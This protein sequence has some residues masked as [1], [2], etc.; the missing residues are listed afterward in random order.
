MREVTSRLEAGQSSAPVAWWQ[1]CFACENAAVCLIVVL[2]ARTPAATQSFGE[3]CLYSDMDWRRKRARVDHVGADSSLAGRRCDDRAASRASP[4]ARPQHSESLLGRF[5]DRRNGPVTAVHPPPNNDESVQASLDQAFDVVQATFGDLD[6]AGDACDVP[7]ILRHAV[8]AV[9]A[10][11]HVNAVRQSDG[12]FESHVFVNDFWIVSSTGAPCEQDAVTQAYRE[13][14]RMLK[15]AKR[16]PAN[17][18]RQQQRSDPTKLR[19]LK[20]EPPDV[21]PDA[22]EPA[23]APL[24]LKMR[25]KNTLRKRAAAYTIPDFDAQ[26]DPSQVMLFHRLSAEVVRCGTVC[27]GRRVRELLEREVNAL[28]MSLALA[29]TVGVHQREPADYCHVFVENV[30]LASAKASNAAEAQEQ[31]CRAAWAKLRAKPLFVGPSLEFLGN[32][33]L[34]VASRGPQQKPFWG[35]LSPADCQ[36]AA[37]KIYL[38]YRLMSIILFCALSQMLRGQRIQDG[39]MALMKLK[40]AAGKL[41]LALSFSAGA[42]KRTVNVFIEGM[43]LTEG[44]GVTMEAAEVTAALAAV[45]MLRNGTVVPGP[46]VAGQKLLLYVPDDK[47]IDGRVLAKGVPCNNVV[48][49]VPDTFP[50]EFVEQHLSVYPAQLG[51]HNTELTRGTL[52]ALCLFAKLFAFRDLMRQAEGKE[53]LAAFVAQSAARAKLDVSCSPEQS[54]Q[55]QIAYVV[56]LNGLQ[57]A[58]GLGTDKV[59]ARLAAFSEVKRRIVGDVFTVSR[60]PCG[61]KL[62][63]LC[64]RSGFDTTSRGRPRLQFQASGSGQAGDAAQPAV[65]SP[66]HCEEMG[67]ALAR[68]AIMVTNDCRRGVSLATKMHSAATVCGLELLAQV[69]R[70]GQTEDWKGTLSLSGALLA[71]AVGPSKQSARSL[72]YESALRLIERPF[73]FTQIN[74]ESVVVSTTEREEHVEHNY[75]IP[76][77]AATSEAENPALGVAHGEAKQ[78][79]LVPET[80][81][82]NQQSSDEVSRAADSL[83]SAASF[84]TEGKVGV[85]GVN[86]AAEE[87][88]E[89]EA[90]EGGSGGDRVSSA[91]PI[92]D[93]K[94]KQAQLLKFVDI[95]NAVPEQGIPPGMLS[96]WLENIALRKGCTFSYKIQLCS[97]S[98]KPKV[99]DL[100]VDDIWV[101]C[102]E[103]MDD[104]QAKNDAVYAALRRLKRGPLRI[105]VSVVVKGKLQVFC[106]SDE[107]D[108]KDL[109]RIQR[110]QMRNDLGSLVLIEDRSGGP[111]GP[112]AILTMSASAN[113]V[114]YHFRPS[115]DG[116]YCT[117]ELAGH[118]LGS[119]VGQAK[120]SKHEAAAE[121]LQVLKSFVPTVVIK[122]RID[123]WGDEVAL[124]PEEPHTASGGPCGAQIPS[125]NVGHKLLTRMGWTGGAI[126]RA[127]TGIVQPVMPT[128]A[129]GRQGLGYGAQKKKGTKSPDQAL[130]RIA[131]KACLEYAKNVVLQDLVFSPALSKRLGTSLFETAKR[132]GLKCSRVKR[133][134]GKCYVV[135]HRM[136]PQQLL[137]KILSEGPTCK[138]EFVMPV[139]PSSPE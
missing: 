54:P 14:W 52:Q 106:S 18:T 27:D 29:N 77:R 87:V 95:A 63:L 2:Y 25:K 86:L 93:V 121:A 118:V 80:R 56:L 13:V 4:V 102:G 7:S 122:Q 17:S 89:S 11:I 23:S 129:S 92:F 47:H 49:L 15:A 75:V 46:N 36:A 84:L 33:E 5:G 108:M 115:D 66:L 32:D 30:W 126:G 134:H 38:P 58:R 41:D 114:P 71:C 60:T 50:R 16:A 107:G 39:Q 44:T 131:D 65:G 3:L 6:E 125:D 120:M 55:G 124:P 37:A 53:D 59:A 91:G 117:V 100:F 103:G 90:F 31:A 104:T 132:Y 74:G 70:V 127:G 139:Q 28:E 76:A 94:P 130:R 1:R 64:L 20:S 85:A 101:S 116:R 83:N 22:P 119:S 133:P 48:I 96:Q 26:V 45:E 78:N 19:E 67:P 72:A 79:L 110:E 42:G 8:E 73:I 10:T 51:G 61:T 82:A 128:E 40:H 136:L 135:S 62:M 138:Y 81:S 68:W 57:F 35:G 99:C 9:D 12:T 137:S 88:A 123:M 113:G 24:P 34:Y 43:W 109:R 21:V 105:D 69:Q 112:V 97:T 98:A 111:Q